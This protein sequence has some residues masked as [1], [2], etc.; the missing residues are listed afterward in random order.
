[1]IRYPDGR[2]IVWI[3]KGQGAQRAVEERVV[4]TGLGFD[5]MVEIVNG[6]EPGEPVVIRGNESLRPGQKVRVTS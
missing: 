6:L 2:T 5:G 1:M 3:A 4:K